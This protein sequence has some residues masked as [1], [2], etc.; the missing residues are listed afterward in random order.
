MIQTQ[1]QARK[2]I[3]AMILKQSDIANEVEIEKTYF[4]KWIKGHV[5]IGSKKFDRVVSWIQ[6]KQ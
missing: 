1:E 3:K 4:N 2:K 5:I 6:N